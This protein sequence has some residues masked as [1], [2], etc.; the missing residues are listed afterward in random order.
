MISLLQEAANTAAE[1]S[2]DVAGHAADAA[3]HG[4]DAAAHGA[5]AAAA[6]GAE[7]ASSGMPQLDFSTF[8]NQ[9]FWLVV[10][11]LILYWVMSRIALPRIA[12]V[13]SD[14]QGAITGDL[15]AA[16]EFKQKAKD[17]EAAYDA[18]LAEARSEAQKIVAANKAEIQKVLD[19]AIADADAEIA[20]RTVESEKRIGQIRDSAQADA[21]TVAKDVTAELVR[22]FGGTAD[23]AQIDGAVDSRLKGVRQ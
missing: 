20:A 6:H 7:A 14:R 8:P 3:A 19:A 11:M 4:A 18:A 17:A 16:E 2:E 15:M 10:T 22:I 13:L 12:S 9:I 1:H 5:E 21:Q 23:Q